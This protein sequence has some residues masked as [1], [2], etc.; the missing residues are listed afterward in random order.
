MILADGTKMKGDFV[1][2]AD[3][4]HSEA[5]KHIIGYENKA[6]PVGLSCFRWLAWSEELLEDPETADFMEGYEGKSHY[7][8]DGKGSRVVWYGCR[9]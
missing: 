3:G 9:E 8:V 1:I 4:L 6:V 5:V 2:G 7:Y